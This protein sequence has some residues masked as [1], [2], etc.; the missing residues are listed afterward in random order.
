LDTEVYGAADITVGDIASGQLI[1]T[2]TITMKDVAGTT[3]TGYAHVRVW[4]SETAYGAAS[5]NNIESVSLNG[6]QVQ[7]VS[8]ADYWQRTTSGGTLTATVTGSASGTNYI[9]AA[10]GAFI[11]SEEIVLIP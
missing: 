3:K 1:T 8:A 5:T 10:V 7:C 2:N 11:T 9:N 6:A 4:M